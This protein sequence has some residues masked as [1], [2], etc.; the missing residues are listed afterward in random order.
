[1]S[2]TTIDDVVKRLSSADTG[3]NHPALATHA[4]LSSSRDILE[5]RTN[6]RPATEIRLKVEAATTLRD[7]LDHYTSGPI[8][9]P[10]L[11]KLMPIF[12]GILNGPC[13]FQSNS[14]EQVSF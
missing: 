11:N 4:P 10:F 14:P 2:G 6:C 8:Y 1:M 13:T 9:A 3:I 12:I 5:T 7:S